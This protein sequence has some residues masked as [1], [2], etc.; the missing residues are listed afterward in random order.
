[1]SGKLNVFSE[2]SMQMH[3][4]IEPWEMSIANVSSEK[5]KDVVCLN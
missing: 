1:M 2:K 5:H 3:R 4:L